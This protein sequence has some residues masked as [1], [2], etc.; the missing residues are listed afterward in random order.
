MEQPNDIKLNWFQKQKM[1]AILRKLSKMQQKDET[2]KEQLIETIDGFREDMEGMPSL[3][4]MKTMN[5]EKLSILLEV[6]I[7][8]ARKII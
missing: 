4:E 6:I 8:E 5:K 1:K 2:T 3:K 7:I